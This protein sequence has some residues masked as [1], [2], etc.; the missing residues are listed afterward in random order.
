MFDMSRKKKP[1]IENQKTGAKNKTDDK[2][3]VVAML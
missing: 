3:K 1:Q 2:N